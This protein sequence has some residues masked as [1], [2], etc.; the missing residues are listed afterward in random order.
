MAPIMDVHRPYCGS[1]HVPVEWSFTA[2]T[3]YADPFNEVE[4]DVV[5]SHRDGEQFA[6]PAYW[7]GGHTWRVRFAGPKPGVYTWRSVCSEESDGG[8][9]GREGDLRIGPYEGDNPL[10]QHGPLR[11]AATGRTLEHQDGTPF[12]WLGDTWWMGLTGRLD[13]PGGFHRL[14]ADRVA[15]GF[16]VIQLFAGLFPDAKAF[17]EQGA[18]EAGH[19]AWEQDWARINPHYFDLADRRM[20]W[21]VRAGL[22]PC[23]FGCQGWYVHLLGGER[24]K[25]HWRYLVARYGAYPL[26]WCL[27]GELTGPFDDA[28]V[29]TDEKRDAYRARTRAAWREVA[30]YVRAVD[31]YGRLLT[32]H[33]QHAARDDLPDDLLDF[34]MLQTGHHDRASL[35]RTVEAVVRSSGRQPVKPTLNG[36]VTYEGMQEANRQEVQRLMFWVCLLSGACGHT[37]GAN[38]LW[39]M[40]TPGRPFVHAGGDPTHGKTPWEEA[41]QLPGSR[42]VGLAKVLLQRYRWWM[43]EPHPEWVQPRWSQEEYLRAVYA[44]GISGEVRVVFL[45]HLVSRVVIH[46]LEPDVTYRGYYANPVDGTEHP[47]AQVTPDSAGTWAAPQPPMRQDWVLVLETTSARLP[48]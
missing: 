42:Q 44:A 16:S 18:L 19:Q 45:P 47:I 34:D 35:P 27:C 8:L 46:D 12:F 11:V 20:E 26:V 10:F 43:F 21:L 2:A 24:M 14:A 37:Y 17:D 38:G 15:K 30:A 9:H 40:N 31:P 25:R 39:Q 4:L 36:E 6:V 3:S 41:Y 1:V 23:L 32:A 28:E 7:A 33:P 48:A 22:A 13:W 29:A 5:F